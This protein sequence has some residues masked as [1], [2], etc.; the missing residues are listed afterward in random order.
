MNS[1]ESA[2]RDEVMLSNQ[3]KFKF[4][5]LMITLIIRISLCRR[6][7]F[8]NLLQ[9][10]R[11]Y[12]AVMPFLHFARSRVDRQGF[13]ELQRPKAGNE[14]DHMHWHQHRQADV[15][16]AKANSVS[17]SLDASTDAPIVSVWSPSST[18]LGIKPSD[19]ARRPIYSTSA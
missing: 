9:T 7:T 3:R 14:V 13:I 17:A 16:S 15:R 11:G 10:D 19:A 8:P 12:I 1:D 4:A 2:Q 6:R 18:V 5:N